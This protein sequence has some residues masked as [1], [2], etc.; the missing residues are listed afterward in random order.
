MSVLT[1]EDAKLHQR[2][3]HDDED[4]DIQS[5][6]DAAETMV[7]QFIGRSFYQDHNSL[8][9]ALDQIDFIQQEFEMKYQK[10]LDKKHSNPQLYERLAKQK[11]YDNEHQISMISNGI[12][13]NPLIRIGVLLSFGYLYETRED[14][15]DLPQTVK[16]VV[17]PYRINWGV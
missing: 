14:F 6:L 9:D 1:I 4:S 2:I 17:Q 7:A 3:D 16:N 12:V 15:E 10:L 13:I 8:E 11:K 5:K